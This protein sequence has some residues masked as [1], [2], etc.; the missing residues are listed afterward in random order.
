MKYN[1]F[2]PGNIVTPGMFAGRA[3]ELQALE[4]ILFQAKHGNP[5]HFLITGERGIGKSSLLFHLQQTAAGTLLATDGTK[6]SFLTVPVELDSTDE[7]EAVVRKVG[8]ELRSAVST[9]ETVRKLAKQS[10]DF[11]KC[12]EVMGVKFNAISEP[13]PRHQ[14]MD[15]L[16]QSIATTLARLEGEVDGCLILIDEA[17]KPRSSAELGAFAKLLTE[18]LT[19]RSA[20]KV[21]LGLAGVT[22]IISK[23]RDSHESAPRIFNQITLEPLAHEDRLDVIKKGLEEARTKNQRPMEITDDALNMISDLSEGYPN[24]VQQF[25]FSAFD[26]DTDWCINLEDVTNGATT[27]DG[28]FDQLGQKYFSELYFDQIGSDEYRDV[29]KAMAKHSDTWVT[30]AELKKAVQLKAST[31][32]DAIKKLKKRGIIISR[33]GKRGEYKLPNKAFAVWI[34]AY[35]QG[36]KSMSLAR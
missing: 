9:L 35:T 36:Q 12:W 13:T 11:L 28:A 3:K 29:L 24:F 19:K 15:E 30:K 7:F 10:W 6:F 25:A 17:D 34:G 22:G 26:W 20:H 27:K 8:A 32:A 31:L 21:A 2:R 23:L 14:L 4:R 1:P 33:L 16:C 18:R 5:Q